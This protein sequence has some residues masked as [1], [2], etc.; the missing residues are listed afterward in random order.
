MKEP[1]PLQSPNEDPW[2]GSR[3]GKIGKNVKNTSHIIVDADGLHCNHCN[4]MDT[5]RIPVAATDY[6]ERVLGFVRMHRPCPKPQ[7]RSPQV[8]LPGTEEVDLFAKMYPQ[9]RDHGALRDTLSRV[10][11]VEQYGKVA[12]VGILEGW[13]LSSVIFDSVAHWARL[14]RAHQEVAT[15]A[16]R[17]EAPIPGLT[18]P[19]RFPMPKELA[20]L[21]GQP[22]RKK[23]GRKG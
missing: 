23:R 7:D 14:E 20:E 17:K 10:L 9:A 15:R 21:L 22:A 5:P 3:L 12:P 2:A 18:I 1:A 8:P 4:E 16:Q 11:P 6:A 13:P 19:G